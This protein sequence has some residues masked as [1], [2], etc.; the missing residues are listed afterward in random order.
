MLL[1]SIAGSTIL[2]G[3]GGAAANYSMGTDVWR[4]TIQTANALQNQVQAYYADYTRDDFVIRN[5]EM[6]LTYG[7]SAVGEKQIVSFQPSGSAGTYAEQTMDVVIED[8]EGDL[9]RA[10]FS[11]TAGRINMHRLGI[12]YTDV[13]LFDTIFRREN[14]EEHVVEFASFHFEGSTEGW[15]ASDHVG[16]LTADNGVLRGQIASAIDPYVFIS[17][18]DFLIGTANA[19]EVRMKVTGSSGGGKIFY[20]TEDQPGFAE[21]RSET[22]TLT[23][24]GEFHTYTV[25]LDSPNWSGRLTDLRLDIEGGQAGSYFEIDYIRVIDNRKA[26]LP[27]RLERIFHAYPDRLYEEILLHPTGEVRIRDAYVETSVPTDQVHGIEIRDGAGTHNDPSALYSDTVEYVGINRGSVGIFGYIY[28]D[29][30]GNGTVTIEQ[31]ASELT[32]KHHADI[33][34][35]EWGAGDEIRFGHRLYND[36]QGQPGRLAAE[37]EL[38]RNPLGADNIQVLNTDA[39]TGFVGYD[40]YRGFYEFTVDHSDFNEAFYLQ[41]HK[42]PAAQIRI[43]NDETPRRIFVQVR[44][45]AASG[46]LEAG[47]VLNENDVLLPLPVEVAKN[48]QGEN[49]DAFYY[50]GDVAFSES[51]FPLELAP[52][53]TLEFTSLHL[54]QNWGKFPLKQ[55]SSVRFTR[56]YYHLSTGVTETNCWVPFFVGGRTGWILPD[57]RTRSGYMWSNQPQFDAVGKNYLFE[58][59][60]SDGN[61]SLMENTNARIDSVGPTHSDVTF[62][63]VTDDGKADVTVRS[64][65]MPQTDENRTFVSVEIVFRDTLHISDT[66][67]DLSLFKTESRNQTFRKLGYLDENNAPAIQPLLVGTEP[68]KVVLGETKPYWTL[69]DFDR[70]NNP[71]GGT[72]VGVLVQRADITAGGQPYH[73]GL[74]VVTSHQGSGPATTNMASMTLNRPQITFEPGDRIE[75]DLI[76]LPWGSYESD[77]DQTL[78]T[79]R[80]DYGLSP[81]SVTAHT[82]QVTADPFVPTVQAVKEAA[83]FTISGGKN[84]VSFAVEGFSSYE[85]PEI[86][87]LNRGQWELYDPS[88]K[89][90][91]GYRVYVDRNGKYGFSYVDETDGSEQRYRVVAK[92][93]GAFPERNW[94]FKQTGDAE[95]WTAH[96]GAAITVSNGALEASSADGS[97][98]I[99]SGERLGMQAALYKYVKINLRNNTASPDMKLYYTTRSDRRWSEDKVITFSPLP[100]AGAFAEY[101]LDMGSQRKWRSLI[102]QM[103]LYIPP[104]EDGIDIDYIRVTRQPS[105]DW[106]PPATVADLVVTAT[107]PTSAVLSWTAPGDDGMSG[108]AA[109][110]DIRYSTTPFTESTWAEASQVHRVPG[111]KEGGLPESFTVTGLGENTTYYFALK[112]VDAKANVSGM[113]NL[114]EG[115]TGIRPEYIRAWE[116]AADSDLEGWRM[117]NQV[118]GSVGDGILR[119]ISTGTDPYILSPDQLAISDPQVYRYVKLRLKNETSSPSG[120][121]FFI[122]NEDPVWNSA[123]SVPFAASGN[124]EE[125]QEYIIDMGANPLWQGTIRGIRLDPASAPGIISIDYI[126]I[127]RDITE[128]ME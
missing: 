71:G 53:Q 27:V 93:R 97:G 55:I 67:N 36:A 107:T 28:P 87:K 7:L 64:V 75:L 51:Y 43:A 83:E 73:D 95:G 25:D 1:L 48:F 5:L 100:N 20:G 124:D 4:P 98:Y 47:V 118:S 119:L 52:E 74:A 115:I 112:A 105:S 68:S 21:A 3:T 94:E 14:A 128:E 57:F 104:G 127:A 39:V 79:L 38:E 122:T 84:N 90:Y 17:D 60:D 114:A 6:E 77:N 113:S 45:K 13:H 99:E 50:P 18:T 69:Y 89:G 59:R 8:E 72:N 88:V 61:F 54:Y 106:I 62:E 101:T 117:K 15:E 23:H 96:N 111:P 42:Q 66:K 81:L 78:Q 24:D 30:A 9:Y 108:K 123:K 70:T 63:F 76:L 110:Y 35:G 49:E 19:V 85:P 33:G 109:Y 120:D 121:I 40:P 12:Y 34:E 86:Y 103:R 37:A 41:P 65:E 116:F 82:G 10:S 32:I 126:R 11:D 16:G 92:T 46:A 26:A 31:T 22:F 102:D 2:A 80:S 44:T 58:Y 56:P 29:M 91:D 125:Y